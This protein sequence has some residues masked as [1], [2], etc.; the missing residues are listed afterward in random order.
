MGSLRSEAQHQRVT[1]IVPHLLSI[2]DQFIE[3]SWLLV[4]NDPDIC[5]LRPPLQF[6][7]GR[8][9]VQDSS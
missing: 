5:H 1:I 6:W 9:A 3:R 4:R 2:R 8:F 7:V